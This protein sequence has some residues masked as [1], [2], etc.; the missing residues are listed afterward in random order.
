MPKENILFGRFGNKTNDIKYFKHLL[1][2]DIKTIVEPFGGTFALTRIIYSD[3]KYKKIVNDND[4]TI[5]K[6][7]KNPEEYSKMSIYYNDIVKKSKSENDG[8]VN[9]K[10]VKKQIEE[11]K[12][13]NEDLK[14]YWISEKIIRGIL[15]K[16]LKNIKHDTFLN[17]MKDIKFSDKNYMEIMKQHYKDKNTFIFIDPPY[18][19]SDN[20]SYSQQK[21]KEGMDMS[22]I[23]Y[24]VYELLEDKKTKAKIMMIINDMKIIRWLYK[25]YIKGEYDKIYQ[26]GK[27]KSKHLIICNYEI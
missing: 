17:I 11:D 12:K 20:S 26:I 23:L 13:F 27:R 22:H 7:Y 1:P 18:L 8:V 14:K 15:I 19:F 16:C 21:R 3:K 6:I 4:E 5:Y 24:E 25:G 10:E 9:C 2:L